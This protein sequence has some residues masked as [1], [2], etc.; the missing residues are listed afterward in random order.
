[1]EYTTKSRIHLSNLKWLRST[2]EMFKVVTDQRNANQNDH[3]TPLRM[4]KIKTSG[5]KS[6]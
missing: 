6:C 3:L 1:M 4:T 5:D 2:K